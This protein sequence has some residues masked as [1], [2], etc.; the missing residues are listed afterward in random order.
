MTERKFT[1]SKSLGALVIALLAAA[2]FAGTRAQAKLAGPEEPPRVAT[3]GIS[4]VS[5]MVT[6]E[7]MR[8]FALDMRKLRTQL[9]DTIQ[10]VGALNRRLDALEAAQAAA[11]P[12]P[13]R[14]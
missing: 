1:L 6:E 14:H 2:F 11:P 3:S 8:Q 4:G 10:Q 12:P 5:D 9:V 13:P 7:E